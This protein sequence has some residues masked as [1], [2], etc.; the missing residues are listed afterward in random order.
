MSQRRNRA[1][2]HVGGRST[3]HTQ[4][5]TSVRFVNQRIATTIV[6]A[7]EVKR[8]RTTDNR[9]EDVFGSWM[10]FADMGNDELVAMAETIV[11]CAIGP[12]Q[13]PMAALN[14][15]LTRTYALALRMT[16]QLYLYH[17]GLSI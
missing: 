2:F 11:E 8:R 16:P 13:V 7:A 3:S 5:D 14:E 1:K 10:P 6:N 9:L 17:S 12:H 15:R 4:G